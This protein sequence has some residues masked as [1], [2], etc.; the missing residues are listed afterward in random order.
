VLIAKDFNV[1]CLFNENAIS[2]LEG[3]IP[4]KNNTLLDVLNDTFSALIRSRHDSHYVVGIN[5]VVSGV[6]SRLTLLEISRIE[7]L[8]NLHTS[9]AEDLTFII[10]DFDGVSGASSH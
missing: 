3:L 6:H 7:S 8:G 2:H 4:E 10:D 9:D 5:S 1:P